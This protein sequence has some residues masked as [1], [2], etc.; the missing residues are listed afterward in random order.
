MRITLDRPALK[1]LI[2]ADPEFHLELKRALLSEI[3]RKTFE[4]D[5]DRVIQEMDKVLF[6]K[7]VE[8]YREDVILTERVQSA[9]RRAMLNTSWSSATLKPE[10][11]KAIEEVVNQHKKRAV[12]EAS[13]EISHVFDAAVRE[14]IEKRFVP[15]QLEERIDKRVD[16]LVE[17]EIDRRVKEKFAAKMTAFMKDM[18]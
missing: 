14:N 11:V 18:K 3:A 1:H 6:A 4:K 10:V 7:A 16:R 8:A 12:M 13:S 2:D 17:E 5:F 15:E 9:L